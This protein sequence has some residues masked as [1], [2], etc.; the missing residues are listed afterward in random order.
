MIGRLHSGHI[1]RITYPNDDVVEYRHNGR[2][3][4]I[5]VRRLADTTHPAFTYAKEVK[6]F[7][8]GVIEAFTYGNGVEHT[9]T[10]NPEYQIEDI[11]DETNSALV[12]HLRYAYDINDNISQILNLKAFEYSLNAISY[13]G[14]DRLTDIS[15]G[16]NI[17]NTQ[18]EYDGLGNI[19]YYQ[20][21]HSTLDYVYDRSDNKNRLISVTGTGSASKSYSSFQYDPSGNV[22][23]NGHRSFDYNALGQMT[24]SGSFSYLYDSNNKRVYQHDSN[25]PAYSVYGYDGKLRYLET[26][27]GGT[28]HI[29]LNNQI[30]ARDGIARSE[31]GYQHFKAF[32]ESV[33][34]ATDNVGYTGHKYDTAIDLN[35][36][37][38]RYYDPVIG[39]FYSN[40]PIDA[41][42]HLS[43]EEGIRGFNRY[44]YAV[45][46][47]YKYTD[48]D[49]KAI[50]G[51]LC[52]IG[53][54]LAVGYA[55]DLAIE[56]IRGD[57]N[58]TGNTAGNV[59]TGGVVAATG[60]F[61]D[62]PRGGIAGGGKAGTKTSVASIANHKAA[63]D[64][65]ISMKTR[66][67]V[68]KVLRKV[69]Y[70]GTAIGAGQLVDAVV[71]R[72]QSETSNESTN[73]EKTQDQ[74]KE[75][76]ND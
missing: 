4:P 34:G 47:P 35:Y 8:N 72:V 9:K 71:D 28:N 16:A 55:F 1:K 11:K 27:D 51:G 21:K 61:A 48:P 40:D 26:S 10:L 65:K 68:T 14:L 52:V 70:V 43:N 62:K 17:G 42:S 13:D 39:R 49:G 6:Y 24:S 44:S 38:A 25:G 22:I 32:G 30:I 66:H 23:Y 73:Q 67:A 76:Q 45:N 41:V 59:A 18:V 46:N 64:G 56:A 69:P 50:C 2:G 19:T 37:Q 12:N 74:E 63:K 57:E 5:S 31:N 53:V 54:G 3:Q 58:S 75:R 7:A 60:P 33:D 29:Y 36:M 15:G 20:T